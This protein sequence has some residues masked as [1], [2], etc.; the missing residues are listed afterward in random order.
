MLLHE[1]AGGTQWRSAWLPRTFPDGLPP[2]PIERVVEREPRTVRDLLPRGASLERNGTWL[3]PDNWPDFRS[4]VRGAALMTRDPDA[5]DT[6]SADARIFVSTCIKCF[7]SVDT[8]CELC[9]GDAYRKQVDVFCS[10]CLH[11][12]CGA[13]LE[14]CAACNAL[15]VPASPAKQC[16]HG[17]RIKDSICLLC[18]RA[19]SAAP[20]ARRKQKRNFTCVKCKLRDVDA[21]GEECEVCVLSN[22]TLLAAEQNGSALHGTVHLE[23]MDYL[24]TIVLMKNGTLT[25]GDIEDIA[26]GYLEQALP[27][28][29]PEKRVKDHVNSV[30][31][32]LLKCATQR[33]SGRPIVVGEAFDPAVHK[34]DV[35]ATHSDWALKYKAAYGCSPPD[36][37]VPLS[38]LRE[39]RAREAERVKEEEKRNVKRLAAIKATNARHYIGALAPCV[40]GCGALLWPGEGTICCRAGDHVLG[41]TYNPPIDAEYLNILRAEGFSANSR[42]L[43]SNLTFAA[44]STSP[45]RED[46]GVGYV[47]HHG[48]ILHLYGKS[49][50][51][52]FNSNAG[53]SGFDAFRVPENAIFDGAE[54][55]I[56]RDFANQLIGVRRY[57]QRQHPLARRLVP[58]VDA[59]GDHIDFTEFIKIDARSAPTGK[60]EIASL[61]SGVEPPPD[62]TFVM[63]FDMRRHMDG[64]YAK[65]TTVQS[66]HALWEL[67]QWPLLFEQGIGGFFNDHGGGDHVVSTEGV[68]LT[69]RDYSRAM[70]F[71]NPRMGY[72]G[73]LMQE[74]LLSQYSRQV[75]NQ[76]HYLQLP[77]F[78]QKL[79]RAANDALVRREDHRA[80]D[81]VKR[82]ERIRMPASVVGS[83]ACVPCA[84]N[85]RF[86]FRLPRI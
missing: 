25:K 40:H 59:P 74:W 62:T 34:W 41:P 44:P 28:P 48:G 50:T 78:Q 46:G 29:I 79:H 70:L 56:G 15:S 11:A 60:L 39:R 53:P 36:N 12:E 67:L 83:K 37:I 32:E 38:T 52:V 49:Y 9:S 4:G 64:D 57:L 86:N 35:D 2:L 33:S 55:D 18:E 63:Y 26:L 68:K 17:V 51:R 75:E 31:S 3:L 5:L 43:N 65:P 71:Q 82:G 76:L 54:R 8:R 22:Y 77:A 7:K 85:A 72:A 81:G 14:S 6:V 47:T 10:A 23:L 73:R 16:A 24:L 27:R 21:E 19:G 58:I 80:A 45:S 1:P 84:V 61:S 42:D 66:N 30:F 20:E 13:I 69:L